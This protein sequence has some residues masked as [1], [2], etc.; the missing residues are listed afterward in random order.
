MLSQILYKHDTWNVL[1]VIHSWMTNNQ[2]KTKYTIKQNSFIL[3]LHPV[4]NIVDEPMYQK[5]SM[6]LNSRSKK[7]FNFW[8]CIPN[9]VS[10]YSL[11]SEILVKSNT[12]A[13]LMYSWVKHAVRC[14]GSHALT[15]SSLYW[16]VV[17]W[18]VIIAELS[19]QELPS[20]AMD[21][22]EYKSIY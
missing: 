2:N 6:A 12:A 8:N 3:F 21:T 10:L 4:C 7:F 1:D 22:Q 16:R 14:H 5:A 20:L 9:S 11:D 13:T 19:G 18:H 17:N 15:S